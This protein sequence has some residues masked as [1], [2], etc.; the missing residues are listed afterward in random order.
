MKTY[1]L[2]MVYIGPPI[3]SGTGKIRFPFRWMAVMVGECIT[4]LDDWTKHYEITERPK[5]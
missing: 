1:K 5:D 2:Q 3:F 4:W